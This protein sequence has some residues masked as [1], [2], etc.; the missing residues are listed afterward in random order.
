MDVAGT[1]L[2]STGSIAAPVLWRFLGD[3]GMPAAR[4]PAAAAQS[5]AAGLVR[6]LPARGLARRLPIPEPLRVG[7]GHRMAAAQAPQDQLE[8]PPPPLLRRSVVAT[9]PGTRAVRPRKGTH[10]ALPL[11]GNSDPNTLA[12]S[13]MRTK[14]EPR[15]GTCG[16]PVALKG[17][18]R[19]RR[20]AWRNGLAATPVP[21]SRPTLPALRHRA[22]HP[23]QRPLRHRR[24]DPRPAHRH[25]RRRLRPAPRTLRPPPQATRDPQ[26]GVD[27]RPGQASGTRTTNLIGPRPSHWT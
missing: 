19:V 15:H 2:D 16:E 9:R 23:R 12:D 11:P 7:E 18:R 25:P 4:R 1:E 26:D 22:S 21:R 8:G 3:H 20:A 6:I 27:Q 5:A 17:A 10:H 13:W 24:A 14:H